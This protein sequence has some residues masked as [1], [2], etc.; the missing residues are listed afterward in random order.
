MA[1]KYNIV[2]RFQPCLYAIIEIWFLF[3]LTNQIYTFG[4]T[5]DRV[6]IC[7][8]DSKTTNGLQWTH[9][10]YA[11][12]Q[13]NQANAL[14]GPYTNNKFYNS[15]AW[16]DLSTGLNLNYYEN[17]GDASRKDIDKVSGSVNNLKYG[18]STSADDCTT[19]QFSSDFMYG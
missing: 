2:N 5:W 9:P 11:V 6:T 12:Q 17:D 15:V 14:D 19:S 13:S 10:K 4:S 8:G 1:S 18:T 3:Q 7:I 16:K